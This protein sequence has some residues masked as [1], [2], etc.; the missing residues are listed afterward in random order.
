[1]KIH[2][3]RK[4]FVLVILLTSTVI[5]GQE[6]FEPTIL[7]LSPNK[8]SN[9]KTFNKEISDFNNS[10]PKNQNQEE[11]KAYLSSSEFSSQPLNIQQMIKSEIEISTK[12]DFFKQVSSISEQFLA[13]RFFEKFPNLLILLKDEKSN[14]SIKNLKTISD[15]NE[16]Q[17]ILNFSSIDIYKEANISYANITIQLYDQNT[18]SILL[19]KSYIGDWNNPGFEFA[20]EN[21]TINCT[22]NN[23]LSQLLN[24]IIYTIAANSPKLI[25]EKQLQQERF[26]VLMNDYLTYEN[27]KQSLLNIFSGSDIDID[28]SYQTLFNDNQ[29]KFVSFF[30]EQVSSQNLKSLTE[31]KKDKNVNI[32]SSNDIKDEEFFSEIPKNYAFVV[33]GVKYKDR[34]YYEKVKVTYFEA[35][36]LE[37]G[38]KLYFNNLQKWNFFKENSTSFNS[39]F[40]ETKLFEK[41]P[42]LKKDPEWEKYGESI[43]KTEEI[44]NRDFIGLYEIVANTLRKENQE[45][46]SAFEKEINEQVFTPKYQLLKDTQPS[47]YSKLSE[48]S[49]IFSKNRKVA[50]NPVLLTDEQGVKTIHYFAAF[51]DSPELFE[52]TYFEPLQIEGNLFGSEVVDQI[53]SLTEWSFSVDNLND[54]DFWNEF[55][56]LKVESDFKYLKIMALCRL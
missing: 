47:I 18:N 4:I 27:N 43:W 8:T 29:T 25:R 21:Q 26:E 16:L 15:T 31:N 9:E 53:S 35:N 24:E 48:H 44:N 30:L 34:W 14:G 37:E 5:Y 55:V 13:Y 51:I 56:L 33:K 12:M 10:I 28:N 2:L 32:I 38:Q 39:D 45:R 36:S 41:V 54:E 1:M 22:L 52:W 7:I 50:I 20:C 23:A 49:L 11:E 19:D 3:I 6:T 46:N 42:D 40:W 17:Y